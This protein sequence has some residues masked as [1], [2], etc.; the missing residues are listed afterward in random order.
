MCSTRPDPAPLLR[1]STSTDWRAPKT[2]R[3]SSW[4]QAALRTRQPGRVAGSATCR[5]PQ[6]SCRHGAREAF[7]L[8]SH[9]VLALPAVLRLTAND[10]QSRSI[11]R[12]RLEQL[13]PSGP[14]CA[15]RSDAL[16]T[17]RQ[18]PVRTLRA[19]RAE[20]APVAEREPFLL[21]CALRIATVGMPVFPLQPHTK[22]PAIARWPQHAS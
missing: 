12:G 16:R 1:E 6:W 11:L 20:E 2:V 18:T 9:L 21:R 10:Y 3:R 14:A 8:R 4:R 22:A 17:H 13:R 19:P 7:L 5:S 15:R